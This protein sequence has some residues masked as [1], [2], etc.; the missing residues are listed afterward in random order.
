MTPVKPAVTLALALLPACATIPPAPIGWDHLPL[1]V[2]ASSELS[3]CQS[4][5]LHEALAWWESQLN[6]D[7]FEEIRMVDSS[8]AAVNG[9][10][11]E[12]VIGVSASPLGTPETLAESTIFY[13]PD[14][15]RLHSVD[16]RIAACDARQVRHELG[17][18]LSLPHS[19]ETDNIMLEHHD[20]SAMT[21]TPAQV[22]AVLIGTYTRL[23]ITKPRAGSSRVLGTV[24][25]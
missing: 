22:Q 13:A 21:I 14:D 8:H 25:P 18:A 6:R 15:G 4:A 11:R 20:E 3:Q 12:G 10:P 5:T 23:A 1:Q 9:L 19:L 16:L 17:H 7:L 24:K 2:L